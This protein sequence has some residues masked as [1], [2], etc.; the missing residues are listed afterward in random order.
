MHEHDQA[1]RCC[2]VLA[3]G[4]EAAEQHGELH[5]ADLINQAVVGSAAMASSGDTHLDSWSGPVLLAPS[6]RLQLGLPPQGQRLVGEGG[7]FSRG[8]WQWLK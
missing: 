3:R 2:P 1:E 8:T 7:K 6:I 4:A 5:A